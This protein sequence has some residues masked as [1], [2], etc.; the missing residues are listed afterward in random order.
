MLSTNLLVWLV[1]M[2]NIS[3]LYYLCLMD[4]GQIYQI[5]SIVLCLTNNRHTSADDVLTTN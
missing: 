3:N 5:K 2:L 1:L 4:Q